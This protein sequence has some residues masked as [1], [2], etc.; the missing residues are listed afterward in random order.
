[1][2][3]QYILDGKTPK[4]EPDLLT[5]AKWFQTATRQVAE[6]AINDVRVSTVFLG[7]DHNLFGDGPPVLFETMVF[8]GDLDQ[9]Q[10]RYSTWDEAER[11]HDEMCKRVKR[12]FN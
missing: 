12:S 3:G 1:M 8:G 10:V 7:V 2:N 5:W 9:E 11:G 6:N 4:P